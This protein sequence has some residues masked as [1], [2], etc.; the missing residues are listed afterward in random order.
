MTASQVQNIIALKVA[1]R[2]V[3][4]ARQNLKMA[5]LDICTDDMG[6]DALGIRYKILGE[7]STLDEL[8]GAI[9]MAAERATKEVDE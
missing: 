5:A 7:L 9:W 6:S 4:A 8:A 1:L 2:D 3:K